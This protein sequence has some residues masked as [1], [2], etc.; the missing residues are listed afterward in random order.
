[1]AIEIKTTKQIG[2][3]QIFAKKIG[4]TFDNGKIQIPPDK[5]FGYIY[6]LLLGNSIGV[7][8]RDY[9]LFED[10]TAI[11]NLHPNSPEKILMSFNNVFPTRM[12]DSTKKINIKTLPSI[13]I[14]KGKLN[15]EDFYP[16]HTKYSSIFISIDS[17]NLKTL[18]GSTL[19]NS[20]FSTIIK[21]EQT[22]LFE[23]MISPEIQKVAFEM[24]ENRI[25]EDL[26]QLY[27]RLKAEELICLLFVELLKRE[28]PILSA[29]NKMDVQKIYEI[30]DNL[31]Q[32]LNTPPNLKNLAQIAGFSESK[33]K[34]LFK[35]IF[36]NSIFNYYQ[37]FRMKEA[38]QLL[39][40]KKMTVSEVGYEMGFINLSHFT[41]VFVEHIGIKPKKYS[42]S[43]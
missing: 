29:L 34:R 39:K 37:G 8:I 21:S 9:S 33:L 1:M 2:L 28:N 18:I 26:Q 27:F 43:V 20:I 3:L 17:E 12:V 14:S 19:E 15:F 25:P 16:S 4:A 30:R 23:E 11:R 6:G 40:E 32:N 35:Q 41:K 22:L 24:V 13:Q 36:G 10:F 42:S 5:G 7:V 38:A 31:L